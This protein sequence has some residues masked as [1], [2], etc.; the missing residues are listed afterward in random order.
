MLKNEK[1]RKFVYLQ[2]YGLAMFCFSS[3]NDAQLA[4]QLDGTWHTSYTQKDED[5]VPY[6]QEQE[7]TFTH[8]AS[9]T[10]DGGRFKEKVITAIETE[11]YDLDVSCKTVCTISGEWEIINGDLYMTY[12]L[13][14]MNVEVKNMD[15]K[16]S[17]NAA[18]GFSIL[19]ISRVKF[20]NII[21]AE[22]RRNTYQEM[23]KCYQQSNKENDKGGAFLDLSIEDNTM[24]YSTSDLGRLEWKR[25]ENKNNH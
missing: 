5:G 13:S 22:I 10:K 3:C 25:V 12:N 16:L 19:G 15:C 20:Q 24:S 4:E 23:Y 17:N 21:T 18:L 7:V 1:I 11:E 6:V 9:N 8:I 2:V 14:T